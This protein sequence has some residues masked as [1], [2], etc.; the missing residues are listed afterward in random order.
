MYKHSFLGNDLRRNL[1]NNL[2]FKYGI[3]DALIIVIIFSIP[4][5]AAAGVINAN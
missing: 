3:K 1:L 5:A 2:T 4:V